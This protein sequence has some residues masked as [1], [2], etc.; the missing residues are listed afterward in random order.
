MSTG[1]ASSSFASSS[2]IAAD[3]PPSSSTH[4]RIS[5][6]HAAAMR[7]PVSTEPVKLTMSTPGWR[8]RYAASGARA[9]TMLI[10][11]GGRPTSSQMSP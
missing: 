10:T 5:S 7:A 9:A 4:G 11:P 3:L 8:T 1:S 2:T 6:P